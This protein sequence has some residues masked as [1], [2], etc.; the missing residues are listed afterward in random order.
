MK[1]GKK[2]L[3]QKYAMM[4]LLNS[5]IEQWNAEDNPQDFGDTLNMFKQNLAKHISF[6]EEAAE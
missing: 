6:L 3:D 1:N 2:S 5:I 4:N